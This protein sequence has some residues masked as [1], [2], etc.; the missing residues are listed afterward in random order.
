MV[1]ADEGEGRRPEGVEEGLRRSRELGGS[2]RG[3]L[4]RTRLNLV[5]LT[6]NAG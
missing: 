6:N 4:A 3:G 2:P 5:R 1:R